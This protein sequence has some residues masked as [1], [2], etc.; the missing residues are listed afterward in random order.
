M[1]G[2]T[3]W[4]NFAFTTDDAPLQ[5]QELST[6]AGI[7]KERAVLSFIIATNT[8]NIKTETEHD[9]TA[10]LPLQLR[11]ASAPIRLP[12]YRTG[13]YACSR[14]GLTL[15]ID[16]AGMNLKSGDLITAQPLHGFA[17]LSKDAKT[18]AKEVAIIK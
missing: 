18:G 13:Y 8:E 14:L 6:D 16:A 1:G 11:I 2:T 15:V 12:G 5:L 4:C 9:D 3:K 10:A 17:G 7:P